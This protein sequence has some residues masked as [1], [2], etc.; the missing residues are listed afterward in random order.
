MKWEKQTGLPIVLNLTHLKILKYKI[1][2]KI[3]KVVNN[4]KIKIQA[5]AKVQN[6]LTNNK[7]N[8]QAAD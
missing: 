8:V 5:I 7:I 2:R 1:L 6:Q 4:L 3:L